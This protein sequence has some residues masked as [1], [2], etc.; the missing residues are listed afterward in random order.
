[1][2]VF[3]DDFEAL[4]S[5]DIGLS[6]NLLSKF[7]PNLSD[8]ESQVSRGEGSLSPERMISSAPNALAVSPK[9]EVILLSL[10][11]R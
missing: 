3:E 11:I 4:L 6:S 10:S 5:Q 1:M 2:M 9:C 7:P 8:T